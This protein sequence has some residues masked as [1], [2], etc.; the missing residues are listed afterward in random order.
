ME[1][2]STLLNRR[3]GTWCLFFILIVFCTAAC[4]QEVLHDLS[5]VEAN[6]LVARLHTVSIEARKEKQANGSWTLL[7]NDA[8]VQKTLLF[9]SKAR[10]LET[11]VIDIPD[12]QNGLF[13]QDSRGSFR[14][15]KW[16]SEEIRQTL[17][18]LPGVLDA[19]VHL[20]LPKQDS[21]FGSAK[22][23]HG[24]GSVLLIVEPESSL[25]NE[26]VAHLV[27]GAAGLQHSEVAVLQTVDRQEFR[28]KRRE[29]A[30]ENT[31]KIIEGGVDISR[32]KKMLSSRTFILSSCALF[33]VGI[34]TLL[35]F[36]SLYLPDRKK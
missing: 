7:V 19:R 33:L 17:R 10:L 18:S 28:Q 14:H 22:K 8:E 6:S 35:I 9:L 34:G 26:E 30:N 20:Y 36:F 32:I 4:K 23:G 31:E 3:R 15:Q 13:S 1:E 25:V 21:L 29:E 24:S 11:S 2:S 12:S 16:V 27:A 5:E